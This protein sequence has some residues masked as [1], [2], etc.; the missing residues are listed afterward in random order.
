MVKEKTGFLVTIEKPHA[1]LEYRGDL[2]RCPKC[3]REV[4]GDFGEPYEAR[5]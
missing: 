2:Y 4:Y 5:K 1:T 3:K